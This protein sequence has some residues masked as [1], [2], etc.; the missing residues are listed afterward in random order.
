M[1]DNRELPATLDQSEYNAQVATINFLYS[2]SHNYD[3]IYY[4][5]YHGSPK[6]QGPYNCVDPNPPNE[7]R[8]PAWSK[9]LSTLDLLTAPYDYVVYID[10]D[11]I[12]KDFNTRIEDF[13]ADFLSSNIVFLTNV[14]WDSDKPCSGFYICKNNLTTRSYIRQWYSYYIPEKNRSHA[15][16]Q[17]ALWMI[18]EKWSSCKLVQGLMFSEH[19]EQFLRHVCSLESD[20]RKTYFKEFMIDHGICYESVVSAIPVKQLN[21]ASFYMSASSSYYRHMTRSLIAKVVRGIKSVN[22]IKSCL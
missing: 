10:S 21:T 12:F 18:F 8:H 20:L 3:F 17:S 9:L 13:F 5:P 19:P 4:Q 11:C 15:Y 1:S 7:F 16:E 2:V 6:A 22:F 14:P